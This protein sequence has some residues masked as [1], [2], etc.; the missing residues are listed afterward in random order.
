MLPMSELVMGIS[1]LVG[2]W[3]ISERPD[4]E[5]DLILAVK[6]ALRLQPPF[7]PLIRGSDNPNSPFSKGV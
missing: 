1:S 5:S 7:I 2:E 4:N 6:S 3:I